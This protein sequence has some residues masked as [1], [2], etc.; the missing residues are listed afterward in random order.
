MIDPTG[1]PHPDF[2]DRALRHWGRTPAGRGIFPIRPH[3]TVSN[4]TYA[5]TLFLGSEVIADSYCSDS[6][7][8]II[9]NDLKTNGGP[10]RFTTK[11]GEY[12]EISG[13]CTFTKVR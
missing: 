13:G 2:G 12:V 1:S 11:K 5:T 8:D 6:G 10:M 7:N 3:S 9:A 4:V